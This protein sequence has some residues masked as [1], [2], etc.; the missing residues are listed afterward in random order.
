MVSRAVDRSNPRTG[1][2]LYV[3]VGCGLSQDDSRETFRRLAR[4]CLSVL[5]EQKDLGK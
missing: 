5:R 1:A 3:E 4:K 2:L